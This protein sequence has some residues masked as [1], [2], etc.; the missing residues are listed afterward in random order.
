MMESIEQYVQRAQ[1]PSRGWLRTAR[2][3]TQMALVLGAWC[4]RFAPVVH[5]AESWLT[6]YPIVA[7]RANAACE[8]GQLH[9]CEQGLQ[10]W[11]SLIDGRPDIRCRLA[12][13][14]AKLGEK[15]LALKSLQVCTRSGLDFPQLSAEPSVRSLSALPGFS[16]AEAEYQRGSLPTDPHELRYSLNDPDLLAEDVAFDSADAS[17]LISSVHERK[18]VRIAASGEVSDFITMAQTPMWGVFAL[19]VDARRGVCWAT[20][21]AVSQ[22]PPFTQADDGRSAVLQIDLRSAT[23]MHRYELSD[24]GP[25][26]FGDMT[27]ADDGAVY[28]SDGR[29]GGVY[30]IRRSH[31]DSLETLVKPGSFR[32]PQTPAVIASEGALLVPDY[33]RGIAIVS[34]APGKGIVA[35]LHHPPELSLSGIDGLY[36]QGHTLVA[37]QNGTVPE[38]ILIMTVDRE[39]RRITNWRVA[40]ARV[41]GLGDPTHGVIRGNEFF[42]LVNSGWDRVDAQGDFGTDTSALPAQIWQIR[43]SERRHGGR[44]R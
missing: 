43:L 13:V 10:R 31:P 37:V 28:V 4:L 38:R 34:L 18:I 36:L 40:L 27:L 26:A 16:A 20:T 11:Q 1:W 15:A 33:S 24:R 44:R 42:A 29:G 8:A 19:A 23:L 3:Q 17:F 9:E 22:S 41:P 21:T 25:H 6:Q 2:L 30:V 12:V 5:A 39:Y 35:W 32:S 7:Q 14:E